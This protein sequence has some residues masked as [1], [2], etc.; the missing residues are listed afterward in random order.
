MK[1]SQ[2][3]KEL[4]ETEKNELYNVSRKRIE[5]TQKYLRLHYQSTD[6]S[7]G[8]VIHDSISCLYDLE[9]VLYYLLIDGTPTKKILEIMKAR[10]N[11]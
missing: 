11:F 9:K 1:K 4:A 3:K 6:E 5:S 7:L 2:T 10:S 8:N